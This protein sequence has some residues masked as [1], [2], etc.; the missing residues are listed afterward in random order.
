MT[1]PNSC[2]DWPA[3]GLAEAAARPRSGGGQV[4]PERQ[5][6]R[7]YLRQ[8]EASRADEIQG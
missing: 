1:I 8:R 5:S 3:S 4:H 6:F 2:E 7:D